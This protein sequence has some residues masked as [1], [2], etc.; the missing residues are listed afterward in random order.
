MPSHSSPFYF[1]SPYLE[2]QG[3]ARSP[4]KGLGG[5]DEGLR[6]WFLRGCPGKELSKPSAAQMS[7]GTP[8]PALPQDSAAAALA[9]RV[10]AGQLFGLVHRVPSSYKDSQTASL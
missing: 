5:R 9:A 2:G 3:P 8:G 10:A 4:K 6:T 7:E 1:C